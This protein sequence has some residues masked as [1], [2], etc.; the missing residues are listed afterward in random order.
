MPARFLA[1]L[2]GVQ[3]AAL[4]PARLSLLPLGSI[5]Y[6][7]RYGMHISYPVVQDP[8]VAVGAGTARDGG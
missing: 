8:P 6:L 3:F 7:A 4:P 1:D 5:E 2:P